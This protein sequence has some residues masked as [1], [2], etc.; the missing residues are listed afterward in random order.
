M[1]LYKV[2][3]PAAY[4]VDGIGIIHT[5]VG[6]EVELDAAEARAAGDSVQLVEPE[7][8]LEEWLAAEKAHNDDVAEWLAAEKKQQAASK[9]P[10]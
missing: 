7:P 6:A 9:A 1:S 2:L 10:R 3:K 5:E 4:A 8:N